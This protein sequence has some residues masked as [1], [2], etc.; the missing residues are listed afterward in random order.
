[1]CYLLS[2]IS[3]MYFLLVFLSKSAWKLNWNWRENQ[4]CCLY[5][6]NVRTRS[7]RV[8]PSKKVVERDFRCRSCI[9][10]CLPSWCVPSSSWIRI[11]H[12]LFMQWRR[13]RRSRVKSVSVCEPKDKRGSSRSAKRCDTNVRSRLLLF[14]ENMSCSSVSLFDL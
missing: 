12:P 6:K 8:S 10:S 14:F 3:L 4:V 1:M 9:L 2:S 11:S 5:N 7:E 13:E